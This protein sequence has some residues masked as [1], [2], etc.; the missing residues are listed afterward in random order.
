MVYS[1]L[2][3]H[4]TLTG[5]GA[6]PVSLGAGAAIAEEGITIEFVEE[7]DTMRA[8]ADGRVVHSLNPVRMATAIVRLL[9]TS[10]TNQRLSQ[11]FAFQT[12]NS[13]F[14]GKNGLLVTNSAQG[15]N[16]TCSDVA[17]AK[18]P[19]VTWAKDA[20]VN[21]W[22]FNIAYCS[23]SLGNASGLLN[24]AVAMIPGLI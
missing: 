21:E 10:P 6:S 24:Q 19:A 13:I 2:D 12:Q 1:F 18:Y 7:K 20:N 23:A 22:R 11:M 9:K 3:T 15:D 17:F 8:G 5:P 4:A 16:Y 14:H